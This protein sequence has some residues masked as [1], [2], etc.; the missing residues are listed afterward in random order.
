VCRGERG[1]GKDGERVQGGGLCR[2]IVGASNRKGDTA[3]TP[4][5]N[6]EK[7]EEFRPGEGGKEILGGPFLR[8]EIKEELRNRKPNTRAMGEKKWT[9]RTQKNQKIVA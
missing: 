8:K 4:G 5:N 7:T 3:G 9:E 6:E 1:P 2:A